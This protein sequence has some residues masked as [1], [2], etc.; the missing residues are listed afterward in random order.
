MQFQDLKS[1]ELPKNFRGRSGF[2][3]QCWWIVQSLLFKHSP[4]FMYGWRRFLLR[5]FGAKIGRKV[6]IRPTVHVQ[7]PW[8]IEIGENSWI[9]DNVVLY[10][11]G[12]I[13]IGRDVVISQ[14][15]YICT[16]SHDYSDRRF[17]IFAEPIVIEDYCWLA[18]D[19]F[20]A[21]GITIEQGTFVGA[22]SSVFNSLPAG[23]VCWGSPAAVI[24]NRPTN[25][26]INNLYHSLYIPDENYEE[27]LST[28]V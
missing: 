21:P 17:T 14:K 13:S 28:S 24:K 11:L 1:F 7:F 6:N 16:G 2:F 12:N 20:V 10:S 5:C 22:R 4:Q 25:F 9:G 3:V 26:S 8:K 19:V 18:T 15:S 27:V 23:K